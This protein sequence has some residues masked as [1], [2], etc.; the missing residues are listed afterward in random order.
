MSEVTQA[1]RRLTRGSM[2][3][4]R[5]R[6]GGGGDFPSLLRVKTS[7]GVQSASY[8]IITRAYSG[9][10]EAIPS[11]VAVYMWILESSSPSGPSWSLMGIPLPILI[12]RKQGGGF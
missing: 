2:A 9:V 4:V 10:N 7:P 5:Y 8:K 3:R 6:V 1:V 11:A 12:S